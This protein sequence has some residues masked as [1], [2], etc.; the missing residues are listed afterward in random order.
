MNGQAELCAELRLSENADGLFVNQDA[1][2]MLFP[3]GAFLPWQRRTGAMHLTWQGGAP[4]T[5]SFSADGHDAAAVHLGPDAA[6]HQKLSHQLDAHVWH[7]A[8]GLGAWSLVA[9]AADDGM[10]E[11]AAADWFPTPRAAR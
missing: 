11:K 8:E 3:V 1:S 10:I 6:L 4:L 7:T 5:L 9:C 2:L